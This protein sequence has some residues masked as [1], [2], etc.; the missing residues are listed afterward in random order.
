MSFRIQSF[1]DAATSDKELRQHIIS[2]HDDLIAAH[3]IVD[4]AAD[5]IGVGASRSDQVLLA[6]FQELRSF[7][8]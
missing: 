5:A 2:V 7:R 3:K 6:V 4:S 8:S 1:L